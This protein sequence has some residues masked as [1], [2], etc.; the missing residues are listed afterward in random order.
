M[1]DF[2]RPSRRDSG[3]FTPSDAS[4]PA[5]YVPR[6]CKELGLST[7]ARRTAA[8][9]IELGARLNLYGDP[10]GYASAAVYVA[11]VFDGRHT[12]QAEVRNVSK[13][14]TPT[15]RRRYHELLDA[16]ETADADR[17]PRWR[18]VAFGRWHPPLAHRDERPE[19]ESLFAASPV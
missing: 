9:L 7:D 8:R 3:R 6:F 17:V 10:A 15:I 2:E 1:P 18:C 14:S 13:I 16:I 12:A 5:A 4:E 11:G 19:R